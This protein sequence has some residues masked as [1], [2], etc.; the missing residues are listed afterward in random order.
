[1]KFLTKQYID[2][3]YE[4]LD[5][6]QNTGDSYIATGITPSDDT[7][8]NV[9]YEYPELDGSSAG[10]T[11]TYIGS[12]KGTLF[13]SS[14]SGILNASKLIANHRG[15]TKQTSSNFSV[16]TEYQVKINWLNDGV[17]DLNGVTATQG[18]DSVNT[19]ELRI[20]SRYNSTNST[21]AYSHAKVK[22]Y[23]VSD[24]TSI[25]RDYI[26]VKRITDNA[27]GVFDLI[28]HKFYGNS[29]TGT[30]TGGSAIKINK[31]HIYKKPVIIDGT[32]VQLSYL[33]S[34]GTQ[35]LTVVSGQI[36]STYGIMMNSSMIAEA[37]NYPA[38][39]TDNSAN[40]RMFYFGARTTLNAWCYGWGSIYTGSS[41]P[42]YLF[43]QYPAGIDKFYTGRLNFLNDKKVSFENETPTTMSGSTQTFTNT[44][45]L[46]FRS[47]QYNTY[48]CKSRIKWAKISKGTDIIRD[49]VPV[50]RM[51]D[52]ELGMYDKLSGTFYTNQGSDTF[53]AGP[54]FGADYLSYFNEENIYDDVEYLESNYNK[55]SSLYQYIDTEKKVNFSKDNVI[56]GTFMMTEAH[57]AVL[58][59]GYEPSKMTMSLEVTADRKVRMYFTRASSAYPVLDISTTEQYPLNTVILYKWSWDVAT[60]TYTLDVS[61]LDGTVKSTL[62]GTSARSGTSNGSRTMC[63]FLDQF[64][65]DSPDADF[66][67][68]FRIYQTKWI[69]DGETILNFIPKKM[70]RLICFVN[71]IDKTVFEN[72]G[73]GEFCI[74]R[75]IYEVEYLLMDGL[76]RFNTYFYPN[77][78]TTTY[79]TH[80]KPTA[81]ETFPFGVRKQTGYD[82]SAAIYIAPIVSGSPNGYLRL[83]WVS[84]VGAVKFNLDTIGSDYEIEVTG[85]YAKINGTE[86]TDT[87][88]TSYDETETF[89]IGT[90]RTTS[91]QAYQSGFVGYFYYGQLLNT[92]TR[93]LY[94]DYIP[95]IDENNN[96]FLFDWVTHTIFETSPQG[97]ATLTYGS[98]V[99][100]V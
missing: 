40:N 24:G 81:L 72:K 1:M 3:I 69:E 33:E 98:R 83:D 61:T 45:I 62:T 20:F 52:G 19:T 31:K 32:Y 47:Y 63:M 95:A 93:E 15:G 86:I 85:N 12:G 44:D 65:V 35:Y 22:K 76:Q 2:E 48:A 9:V 37:D 89:F 68:T 17:I 41:T 87:T 96:P 25:I 60:S 80:I 10:I 55:N 77:T 58:M 92:T 5:Y 57:R 71:T 30:F 34:T 42:R 75:K 73:T 50:K 88:A 99:I 82:G 64:R 39:S 70:N 49:L 29:G 56:S 26:P 78:L 84:G 90:C 11:G 6:I 46:L 16:N 8:I 66:N 74:G 94:R 43:A 38:G 7:G 4:P 67:G 18:S 28:N 59:G 36:D 51:S 97:Q 14:V 91:T 27:I 21:W 54:I 79:K 100:R 23:Q 13:V 53:V